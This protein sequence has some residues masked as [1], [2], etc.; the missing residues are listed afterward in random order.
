[1][2]IPINNTLQGAAMF[3]SVEQTVDQ[4]LPRSVVES[5]D[6]ITITHLPSK[7]LTRTVDTVKKIND[8]A[9]IAKAVPHIAARNL[10]SEAELLNSCQGFCENGVT[11]ILIIGGNRTQ[12]LHYSSVY[13]LGHVIRDFEFRKICGVYPQQESFHHVKKKKYSNFSEGITQFCMKPSLLN[14]FT[15]STRIGVPSNCSAKSLLKYA[16]LCGIAK[17][18]KATMQNLEGARF[19]TLDGFNTRAFLKKINFSSIHIYNFGRI[20][21]TVASLRD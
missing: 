18:A 16:K 4:T 6:Q 10:H 20:E 13:E 8:Q 11:N 7:T 12:G 14:E 19:L 9:G 5:C 17:T 15:H 1:M 2:K 21:Q 3:L